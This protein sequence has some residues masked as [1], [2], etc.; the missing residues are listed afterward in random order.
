MI[1]IELKHAP[2]IV[3]P[4]LTPDDVHTLAQTAIRTEEHR[5]GTAT[6]V[7]DQ[8]A[9]A[10][11]PAYAREKVRKGAQP[12]RDYRL[13]G[14]LLSSR[15]VVSSGDHAA[16]IGFSDSLQEAKA[17]Q[18]ETYEQMFGLSPR[19]ELAVGQEVEDLM[20]LELS[21]ANGR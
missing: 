3:L 20:E 14:A 18:I 19:D 16:A 5:I 6:N 8:P 15:D 12:V 11:N 7:H 2:D 10:L 21:R 17:E 13:T 1:S 4:T 9:K